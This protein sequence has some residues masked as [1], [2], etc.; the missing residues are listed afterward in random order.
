MPATSWCSKPPAEAWAGTCCAV[1]CLACG[2]GGFL[3]QSLPW[4][5]RDGRDG[6]DGR[7]S[8]WSERPRRAYRRPEP[9]LEKRLDQ[10]MTAGRQLVD[11]VAG[12]RPGGRGQP[13]RMAPGSAAG[14]A[15]AIWA[16]GWRTGS[17]GCLRTTTAGVSP[18]RNG[19]HGRPQ[20]G[21]RPGRPHG[22]I[23]LSP[24]TGHR[25]HRA[26]GASPRGNLTAHR[27][28]LTGAASPAQPRP[29]AQPQAQEE[30]PDD[31]SFS[32]NRWR[33]GPAADGQPAPLERQ[34]PP[35]A[36]RAVPR[37]SRRRR[38]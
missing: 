22:P 31:T 30:W 37:S 2:D 34:Q 20:P 19:P 12:A 13:G 27:P 16:D 33:R 6:H 21:R 14:F 11:G 36:A 26:A 25:N 32:V 4:D 18:G 1:R 5:E 7:S 35:T 17:T 9:G 38:D 23:A 29:Q 3:L 8:D 10:W 28:L 24:P 15:R